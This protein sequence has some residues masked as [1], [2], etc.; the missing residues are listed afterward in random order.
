MAAP[1][2]RPDPLVAQLPA[3][4]RLAVALV[5]A[6]RSDDLVQ[7]AALSA[8]RSGVARTP[9]ALFA[10]L[11]RRAI[12]AM[13]RGGRVV[14]GAD[15][16]E[17]VDERAS[18]PADTAGRVESMGALVGALGRLP[19]AQR[20]ALVLCYFDGAT[21]AEAAAQLGV[22]ASTIRSRIQRGLEALRKDLSRGRH[23]R[24]WRALVL[25]LAGLRPELGAPVGPATA[26]GAASTV[27][28]LTA[29]WKL[30]TAAACAALATFALIHLNDGGEARRDASSPALGRT[31]DV[32][33]VDEPEDAPPTTQGRE[34]S[35]IEAAEGAPAAPRADAA[36]APAPAAATTIAGAVTLLDGTPIGDGVQ[37]TAARQPEG[38][39]VSAWTDREGRFLVEGLAEGEYVVRAQLFGATAPSAPV[40]ANAGE[41]AVDL[42][43]DALVLDIV[44]SDADG[45]TD[46]IFTLAAFGGPEGATP[47]RT[48]VHRPEGP[49]TVATGPGYLASV[50]TTAGELHA[51]VDPGLP[52]G[53]YEVLLE[54]NC[55]AL[56]TLD[57]ALTGEPLRVPDR[58]SVRLRPL[59]ASSLPR[60][61]SASV[62]ARRGEDGRVTLALNGGQ[63][64]LPGRYRVEVAIME[65]PSE[66]AP[67]VGV[68]DRAEVELVAG[69]V[70]P[71]QVE[72]R[73]G[74]GVAVLVTA[75]PHDGEPGPMDL[76]RGRYA[77][78]VLDDDSGE[79]SRLTMRQSADGNG[80]IVRKTFLPDVRLLSRA[81]PPGPTRLRLLD[82]GEVAAETEVTLVAGDYTELD[83]NLAR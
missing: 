79:W 36:E 16:P 15:G 29:M 27:V 68:P 10:V 4:R 8:L 70:A 59:E 69:E 83:F 6:E 18:D 62:R 13:R 20:E 34:E 19:A 3:L 21:P 43:V 50:Q 55:G 28:S 54:E 41:G 39:A 47:Y 2:S 42:R 31:V 45:E 23:D 80:W 53:R 9:G 74:A 71:I 11:R 30:L 66:L 35:P 60:H 82:K 44:G 25:P 67:L 63:G 65:R 12:D 38:E 61:Q 81:L 57:V 17:P 40:H 78:E 26:V 52:S 32:A 46:T 48:S 72:I 51:I 64:I 37:V 14:A 76:R 58:V 49:V 24:D 33:A 22:N 1:P 56:A 5:G 77:V 7:E 75:P 73:R